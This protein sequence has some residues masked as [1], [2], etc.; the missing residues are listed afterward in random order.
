MNSKYLRTKRDASHVKIQAELRKRGYSVVDLSSVGG[1][2]CDLLVSSGKDTVL[3]ELK[4]LSGG[5]IYLDQLRFMSEWK[6][7]VAFAQTADE[8]VAIMQDPATKCLQKHQRVKIDLIETRYRAKTKDKI[9][10]IS[11]STFEKLMESK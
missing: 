8:C 3:I 7:Y 10:R 9:P 1:G 4:E 2:V 6:G 5:S 11:F